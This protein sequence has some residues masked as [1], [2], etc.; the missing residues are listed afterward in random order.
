MT[1]HKHNAGKIPDAH[2]HHAHADKPMHPK[3][4]FHMYPRPD[5]VYE[6]KSSLN[7]DM[8]R[9]KVFLERKGTN[10]NVYLWIAHFILGIIVAT[11]TFLMTTVEDASSEFRAGFIQEI[12]D[13]NNS[14]VEAW[15]AY[16][17]YG[18]FFVLIACLLTIYVGPGA[19]G[20]G[21]AEIMGLLNGINY[22]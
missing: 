9:T 14:A 7:F 8:M 20:S 22:P 4:S 1:D 19:N 21:V 5:N 13:R 12:I 16:T 17:I 10:E 6:H 15:A 11:V 18:M 3:R 2:K